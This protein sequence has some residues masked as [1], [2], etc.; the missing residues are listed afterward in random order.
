MGNILKIAALCCVAFYF[1]LGFIWFLYIFEINARYFMA[2]FCVFVLIGS[3][4]LVAIEE[5][6]KDKKKINM[7]LIVITLSLLFFIIKD[8]SH[9]INEIGILDENKVVKLFIF[10]GIFAFIGFVLGAAYIE[11][12]QKVKTTSDDTTTTL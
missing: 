12:M 5:E 10:I 3:S 1:I 8:F 2:A 11:K 6:I 9:L 7:Y 4:A